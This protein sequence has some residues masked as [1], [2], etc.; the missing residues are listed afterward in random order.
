[1]DKILIPEEI[2]EYRTLPPHISILF[3]ELIDSHEAL[4]EQLAVALT[5]ADFWKKQAEDSARIESLELRL[6]REQLAVE[7]LRA[8]EISTHW[9]QTA[10]ELADARTQLGL[11]NVTFERVHKQ[12]VDTQADVWAL[13]TAFR[14]VYVNR[15]GRQIRDEVL[16]RSGVKR[17]MEEQDAKP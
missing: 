6:M 7:I 16:S 11:A 1:M 15:S 10:S 2:A 5:D 17:V 9:T 14:I 8:V 4:R 12:L 13:V 3:K